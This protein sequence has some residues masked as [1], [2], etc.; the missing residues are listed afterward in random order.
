[1]A[2]HHEDR[3]MLAI[4]WTGRGHPENLITQGGWGR[5]KPLLRQGYRSHPML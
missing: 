4:A 5:L 2:A 1:V 3:S